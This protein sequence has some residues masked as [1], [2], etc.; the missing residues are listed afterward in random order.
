M[1]L[2]T[3]QETLLPWV[4]SSSTSPSIINCPLLPS[5][6]KKTFS[7]SREKVVTVEIVDTG[8]K[9]HVHADW[10]NLH[11]A[12]HHHC[13]SLH[14]WFWL[15]GLLR[16]RC[17]LVSHG[18][19]REPWSCPL[20]HQTHKRWGQRTSMSL[21]I[22]RSGTWEEGGAFIHACRHK[23]TLESTC[24]EILNGLDLQVTLKEFFAWHTSLKESQ[25]ELCSAACCW[26]C[27]HSGKLGG[28]LWD[29]RRGSRALMAPGHQ[30]SGP[31]GPEGGWT[32]L[33]WPMR[34]FSGCQDGPH[35]ATKSKRQVHKKDVP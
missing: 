18:P 9:K 8:L 28:W 15:F 14:S 29:L 19:G 4:L 17:I 27:H 3:C 16:W 25:G 2:L 10:E 1:G 34:P 7:M 24:V 22:R 21:G 30:S 23:E 6:I 33:C 26:R 20:G 11:C 12:M 35:I 31:S 5:R 32:F 13:I